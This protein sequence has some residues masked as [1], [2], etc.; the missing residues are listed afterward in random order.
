MDMTMNVYLIKLLDYCSDVKVIKQV[1][2]FK[3]NWT[4]FSERIFNEGENPQMLSN[5]KVF[6]KR[7]QMKLQVD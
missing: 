6:D 7:P 5:W 2:Y 1:F 3:H 4:F